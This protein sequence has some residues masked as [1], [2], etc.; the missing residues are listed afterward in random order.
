MPDLGINFTTKVYLV[1]INTTISGFLNSDS[2][3]KNLL[4]LHNDQIDFD[5]R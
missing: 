3:R 1:N 4:G 5:L 2:H